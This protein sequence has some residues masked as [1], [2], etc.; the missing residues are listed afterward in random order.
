MNM[1]KF[2]T[3]VMP[4]VAFTLGFIA[5]ALNCCVVPLGNINVYLTS[6]AL[7]AFEACH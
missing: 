4:G 2:K 7:V 3:C 5:A 1:L 6:L